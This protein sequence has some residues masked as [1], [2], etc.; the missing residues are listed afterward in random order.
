MEVSWQV[1][2]IRRDPFAEA[3]R[4]AVEV[5]KPI[6]ERGKYLYAREYGV[7]ESMGVEYEEM[8][9]MEDEI[10]TVREH[11]LEQERLKTEKAEILQGK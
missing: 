6:G 11:R 9:K 10:R 2:G 4:I 5:D 3:H 7:P 1:T 8:Q